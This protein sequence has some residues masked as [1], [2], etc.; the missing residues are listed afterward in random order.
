MTI[1]IFRNAPGGG[2]GPRQG[3]K[4]K[5]YVDFLRSEGY[6]P[7]LDKD[8]D[9]RFKVEGGTYV[10]FAN[11]ADPEYFF[12]I[13]PN[14][15]PIENERE[16]AHAFQAACHAT[17]STKVA[18]VYPMGDNVYATIE[19]LYAEPD[20]FRPVFQRA[21]AMLKGAVGIFAEK[22]RELG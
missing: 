2:D 12:I 6:T 5:L 22:M 8:G 10:L 14:F 21:M 13:F 20:Q 16:R 9:I 19:A 18:K 4:A 3:K 11:E 17:S 15:W 1:N 7:E